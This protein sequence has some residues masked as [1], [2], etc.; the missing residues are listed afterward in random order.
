[1][2]KISN[3]LKA[4]LYFLL[5]SFIGG[6]WSGMLLTLPIGKEILSSLQLFPT[7]TIFFVL[8]MLQEIFLLVITYIVIEYNIIRK[9]LYSAKSVF[10]FFK[11]QF[12]FP[13]GQSFITLIFGSYLLMIFTLSIISIIAQFLP[14]TLYGLNGVQKTVEFV[15]NMQLNT[16]LQII[17]MGVSIVIIAP[18]VEEIIYRGMVAKLL[19][20]KYGEKI[21]I[22]SSSIIFALIHGEM[23]IIINLFVM[24]TFLTYIYNKTGSLYYSIFYHIFINGIAFS[25]I[26]IS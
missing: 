16:P 17:L 7:S 22:I 6:F 12:F 13:K 1:M 5:L 24:G 3:E 8:F 4:V 26:M 2:F 23:A 10:H 15:G 19:I 14:F 11:Q 20:N 18:I 25:F 21:G 9:G